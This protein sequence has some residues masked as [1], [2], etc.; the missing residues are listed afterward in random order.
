MAILLIFTVIILG[1]LALSLLLV[2]NADKELKHLADLK[3]IAERPLPYAFRVYRRKSSYTLLLGLGCLAFVIGA[4]SAFL[5]GPRTDMFSSVFLIFA[6]L[7]ISHSLNELPYTKKYPYITLEK[8]GL[9]F[10]LNSKIPWASILN[11]RLDSYSDGRSQYTYYMVLFLDRPHPI[12]GNG[13]LD[14]FRRNIISLLKLLKMRPL[15]QPISLNLLSVEAD[16][17]MAYAQKY[18]QD[19]RIDG[20]DS[21]H[22]AIN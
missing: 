12:S 10:K 19:A 2:R 7:L 4:S 5:M 21:E 17:I 9:T 18:L 16:V 14:F 20:A 1:C 13:K 11:M 3:D 15:P 6:L 8:D 22:A